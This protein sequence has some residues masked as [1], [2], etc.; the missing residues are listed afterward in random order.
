[1]RLVAVSIVKNEADIIEAFVRHTRTLVDHHL[2]FDHDSTD[3]TREILAALV[4]EGLPVSLFTDGALG[5][6][7]QARSN[8]LTRRAVGE[9]EADWVLPLDADEFLVAP[10]RT[11]LEAA[12]G[13]PGA[14]APATL[15]LANYYPT[16]QDDASVSS[17]VLRLQHRAS[18]ANSSRK[19]IV[20]RALAADAGVVAGKGSHVL[21]RGEAALPDRPL[22]A[23]F[24]LAHFAL[25][26]LGQQVLRVVTAE[27]QKLGRGQAHAGLDVHY[28][29]GF[30]LLAEH[31]DRFEH[32]LYSRAKDLT[33]D[34]V[35]YL[36]GKL[37]YTTDTAEW[38]RVSR[39][40]LPFL[41]K[42]AR[43]HGELVD[44]SG[45]AAQIEAER[46]NLRALSPAEIPTA[47][48]EERSY[49]TGFTATTGL[50]PDEG[51]FAGAFLPRFRWGMAPETT[52]E[53]AASVAGTARLEAEALTYWDG[54]VVTPVLNGVELPLFAFPRV[55]QKER[56][57]LSLPLRAGANTLQLR[58]ARHHA[59]TAD[60]RK[61]AVIY[62]SLRIS[63]P[64]P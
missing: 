60:P 17:P 53:I 56:L 20:P 63:L 10:D 49:F 6:L 34:P 9:F 4:R 2:I 36:G 8:A 1:M 54:Q 44:R 25:R 23:G 22:P 45:G 12:L 43:S 21:Y 7:Q 32:M 61:L 35:P 29:L 40:L 37:R 64:A 38:M 51:P 42:L 58:Y 39:A 48:G 5:N 52:L 18:L 14:T 47:I 33:R 62:L 59:S 50:G 46:T 26:S 16:E 30:Q 15:P 28:R 19:V 3:G 31:P 24:H 13:D 27:L 55:N 11:A 57:E 41:E